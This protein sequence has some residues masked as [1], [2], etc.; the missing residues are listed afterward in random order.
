MNHVAKYKNWAQKL[1]VFVFV[2]FVCHALEL[3]VGL[4]NFDADFS[5][6]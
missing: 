1:G 3:N 5:I 2:L 6:L 4:V